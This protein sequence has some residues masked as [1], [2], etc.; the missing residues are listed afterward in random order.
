MPFCSNPIKTRIIYIKRFPIPPGIV[1]GAYAIRPYRDMKMLC[2]DSFFSIPTGIVCGAYA[3]RPCPAGWKKKISKCSWSA[4]WGSK[5]SQNVFVVL[6]ET[7]N[8]VQML[9]R[10]FLRLKIES[11]YFWGTFWGSKSNQNVFEVLFDAQNRVEML[12]WY[13]LRLK[14]GWKCFWGLS[15]A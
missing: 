14:M 9:L 6:F 5:S 4:F 8:G 12:L 7:Q 3:I 15:F 10:C 2:D 11:K 1:C 13:F